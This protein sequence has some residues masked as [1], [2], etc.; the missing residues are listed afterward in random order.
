MNETKQ[1]NEME[2][3]LTAGYFIAGFGLLKNREPS[4]SRR[5]IDPPPLNNPLQE[6]ARLA[7][8]RG[9]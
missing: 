2:T 5:L 7:P 9:L 1:S 3:S 4:F 6:A 8:G